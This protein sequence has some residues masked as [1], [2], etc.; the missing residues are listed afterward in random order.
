VALEDSATGVAAARASCANLI[1]VPSQPGT[2]LDGDYIT[3]TLTDPA[4]T[5]WAQNVT[6]QPR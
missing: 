4:L 1:T 2:R 6:R 3:P 5:D